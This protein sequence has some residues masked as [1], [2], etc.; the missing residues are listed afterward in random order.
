MKTRP[1]DGDTFFESFLR[2]GS[3]IGWQHTILQR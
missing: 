2:G 3:I 1:L